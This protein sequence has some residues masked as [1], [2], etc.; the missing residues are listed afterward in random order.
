MRESGADGA[1][2]KIENRF[3]RR[4]SAGEPSRDGAGWRA[5]QRDG[6]KGQV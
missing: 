4:Q 6:R 2:L 5:R 3:E 1:E